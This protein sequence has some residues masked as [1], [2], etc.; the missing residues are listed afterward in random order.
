[1]APFIYRAQFPSYRNHSR[2]ES[3]PRQFLG[4]LAFVSIISVLGAVLLL[5]LFSE[6][7]K[8]S[9]SGIKLRTGC[10]GCG[11]CFCNLLFETNN[12]LSWCS[13]SIVLSFRATETTF[14]GNRTQDRLSGLWPSFP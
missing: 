3:N 6:L 14:T 11:L 4:I 9:L 12:T 13:S 2:K 5:C 7:Q 1:L 10:R 8:T